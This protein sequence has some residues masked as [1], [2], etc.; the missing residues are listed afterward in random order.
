[1][2]DPQCKYCTRSPEL[3]EVAVPIRDMEM[4]TLYL[5][6]DQTYRGR[7]ILA[8]RDHKTELFE[9]TEAELQG[10]FRDAAKAAGAIMDAFPADKINY[11]IFGDTAPH[12]HMH[13]VPKKREGRSWGQP[14]EMMPAPADMPT[15]EEYRE[16]IERI[17]SRLDTRAKLR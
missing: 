1:M 10:Y 16:I 9:L 8:F 7:C 5:F 15:E 2:K 11:G 6:R 4:S 12:I 17:E 14:F 13:L 3:S